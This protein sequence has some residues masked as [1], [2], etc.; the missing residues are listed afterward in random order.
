MK[1]TISIIAVIVNALLAAGK[2]FVG[3][4]TGS[5]LILAEGLHSLSDVFASAVGYAGIKISQQPSD[6]EH[7]YGHY[8]YEVLA[9]LIITIVLFG[10]GVSAIYEAYRGFIKP[11]ALAF[12]AIAFAVMIAS[13]IVNEVMARVKIYYGKKENSIS[14]ISDGTHSRV[15]VYASLG[16]IGG[17]VVARYWIFADAL[18]AFLIGIYIVKES[19]S[20]GKEAVDSLLDV[21]AGPE[22][23]D[24]I[25]AIVQERG[26]EMDSLKTQ[27]KGSAVTANLEIEL[28]SNLRIEEATKIS[29]SLREGLMKRIEALSYVAIQIKSHEVETG[30]YRP[31]F[32][33][34]FGWQRRGKF[35]EELEKAEGG[36]P[37]GWCVCPECG[38]RI[39]HQTG[40]P[41]S[42]LQCPNCKSKLERT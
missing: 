12:S 16:V 38:Y 7:P 13:A 42:T 33:K 41:C 24:K 28:P 11:E 40:V 37:G 6:K 32:G 22:I 8:K 20:L 4:L 14:L 10:A 19:F 30:F 15:D 9:G 39:P 2:I 17:L 18:F 34:G 21:S 35:K 25:A 29:E 31:A 5:A 3:I 26:I 36:G 1:E 27:K 23:D